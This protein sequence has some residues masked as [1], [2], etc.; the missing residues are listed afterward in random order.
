MY[1]YIYI[2]MLYTIICVFINLS[3]MHQT[4][5]REKDTSYSMHL[6]MYI[7]IHIK[8]QDKIYQ[9]VYFVGKKLVPFIFSMFSVNLN[10]YELLF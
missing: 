8:D 10:N 9:N 1:V 2:D 6:D 3:D 5:P 7:V 4:L